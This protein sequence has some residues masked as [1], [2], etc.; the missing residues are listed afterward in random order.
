M[1]LTI[2][3]LIVL[4]AAPPSF[5]QDTPPE[6]TA[7]PAAAAPANSPEQIKKAQIELKRLDCLS[8]RIDGKLGDKTREAVKK[9]W[10]SDKRPPPTDIEITDAM[11]ADLAEHGDNYCRPPR[12]VFFFGGGGKSAKLPFFAPGGKGAPV[13]PPPALHPP[14]PDAQ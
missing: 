12:H 5:A 1:K 10:A 3:A 7:P 11:I 2:V 9:F 8:G 14:Q 13:A 6:A 4:L